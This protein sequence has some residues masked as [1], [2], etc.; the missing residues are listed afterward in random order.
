MN[1]LAENRLVRC[2]TDLRRSGRTGLAPYLT[3]GDGGLER[4]LELLHACEECGAACVEL[5][6]P[7]SDPIADGPV[8]QTAAQRALASGTTLDGVMGIVERFRSNGG[9][10]PVIAFSYLNPLLQS[11]GDDAF[12][13]LAKAGF[14]GLLI[15]DLPVEEAAPVSSAAEAN[16]LALSLFCAPTTS[17]ERLEL[18]ASATRGFLYVVGRTGVTGAKTSV[19][20]AGSEYLDRVRRAVPGVPLGV[21]FGLRSAA[22]VAAVAPFAELA[23]VGSAFVDAVHS[24]RAGDPIVAARSFLND[25]TGALR[26]P[27]PEPLP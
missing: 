20:G 26:A 6:I 7:F 24:A 27:R 3:A 18:A 22:Q 21:G 5:G 9:T 23:I 13:A 11:P 8:L 1:V 19:E 12:A 4:T 17:S 25:L 10:L 15:P 14:D 16:G 2:T